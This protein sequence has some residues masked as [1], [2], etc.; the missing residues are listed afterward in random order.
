MS[1][2]SRANGSNAQFLLSEFVTFL[3]Y[4]PLVISMIIPFPA[5]SFINVFHNPVGIS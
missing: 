4:V 2:T 5:E 3:R 1:S